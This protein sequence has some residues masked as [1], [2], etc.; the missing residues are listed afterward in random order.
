MGV[1]TSTL[2]VPHKVGETKCLESCNAILREGKLPQ[3]GNKL[4]TQWKGTQ[5]YS[6]CLPHVNAGFRILIIKTFTHYQ[7]NKDSFSE[8]RKYTLA[9][10]DQF[11]PISINIDRKPRP[12]TSWR[13]INNCTLMYIYK[14]GHDIFLYSWSIFM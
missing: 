3:P 4:P 6:L 9:N 8:C 1:W 11:R 12:L 13:K 2:T 14:Q 5:P 10:S 7:G